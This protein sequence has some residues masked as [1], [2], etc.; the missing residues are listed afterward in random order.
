MKRSSSLISLALLVLL[1]FPMYG[2]LQTG[3]IFGHV[4]AKDGSMLPGVTVTLTGVGAPGTFVTDASGAFRFLNLSPG[5]YALKAELAGFGTSTRQGI[6]VNI[7]RNADVTMTLNPSASES[8]TVTAEAP[9]LDVRRAGTG[10]TV[11]KVELEKVPTGR[12]PWVIL[13]Q[14]PGV[15]IDRL[16]VGGSES[17]QQ[18]SYT[19]KGV[20]SDQATW[21]VDGVNIT[22]VGA[23]GSSPTYYDFDSFEEMQVTTG[24]TDVRILTPGVQLNMVTKRGTNDIKGSARYFRTDGSWQSNPKIPGN[25]SGTLLSD[26]IFNPACTSA[27]IP[28]S[29]QVLGGYLGRSNSISNIDDYGAEA[30]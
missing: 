21:N 7:G 26:R 29:C 6:S 2:Q 10:A 9:L 27:Q 25:A 12:D 14:T 22:D 16:N 18:S 20:T 19:A 24:G 23:L 30:G 13:Q 11:T 15:L 17:G 8:I 1:C 3:N 5:A 28:R 4:Q